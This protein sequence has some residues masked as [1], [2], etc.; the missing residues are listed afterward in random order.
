LEKKYAA[1]FFSMA[2]QPLVGQCLLIIEASWSHSKTHRHTTLGRTPLDELSAQRKDLH[3]TTHNTH[4]RQTN[5]P[6]AEFEPAILAC[7]RPQTHALDGAATGIGIC[8]LY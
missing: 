4:N 2:Q 3:L 5:M 1:Y 7:E 8:S 6:P